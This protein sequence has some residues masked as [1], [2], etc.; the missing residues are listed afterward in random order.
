M[1]NVISCTDTERLNFLAEALK[2][3][4]SDLTPELSYIGNGYY[5][6]QLSDNYFIEKDLR[7]AIDHAILEKR[8][9][10][11]HGKEETETK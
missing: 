3:G 9:A 4:E 2:E 10:Q 8:K 5:E 11:K 6:L 1:E 7:V